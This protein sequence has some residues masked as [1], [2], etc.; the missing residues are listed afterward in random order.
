MTMPVLA[1]LEFYP[2][3][4]N[5]APGGL[6]P[7]V[8]WSEE[9]G[10]ARFLADGVRIRPINYGG[11]HAVGIWTEPWCQEPGSPASGGSQ[12]KFGLRPELPEPFGPI[13][14]WAY[15]ECDATASR[16]E[17]EARVQQNFR[18][19]EP[20]LV[21]LV[22]GATLLDAVT[23]AAIAV[24]RP[25][26]REAVAYLEGQLAKT[27][28]LGVIHASPEAAAL[29]FGIVL[30]AGPGVLRTP[31]GHTWVFG[32]G[33]VDTLG[34]L[35]VATSPVFGWRGPVEVRPVL[36]Q[37]SNTYAA[38]AERSLVVAFEKLV[39]AVYTNVDQGS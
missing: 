23:T 19:M 36:D 12:L 3:P 1:P 10:P 24:N 17:V 15:D 34:G 16:A 11:E 25:T 35:V 8:I 39:G 9:P 29:E 27:N 4:V 18:L 20:V 26:F 2:P 33:Y 5:P 22:F 21:E 13:T 7:A 37:N 6:F 14:T 31:L 32:G 30:P 28:T 38:V